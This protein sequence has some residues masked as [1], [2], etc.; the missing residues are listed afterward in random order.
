LALILAAL[1]NSHG[2]ETTKEYRARASASK[3]RYRSKK[4][5]MRK[6]AA[7]VVWFILLAVLGSA[8]QNPT[9]L[10]PS[11][12][13][14]S[15]ALIPAQ[16]PA[17]D[18]FNGSGVVDP[19]VP[20][21][22]KLSLLEALDRGLK[23]NLGLLLSQQQTEQAR[24]QYR[25]QLSTL[26]PNISATTSESINQINLA[27]FGI[28]LPAGLTSP[29]I[30]P[31][32]VFDVHA[33][34]SETVLDFNARNKIRAAQENQKTAQFTVQD[35]RELVVLVVG[36]QYLLTLANAARLET[37]KA[38]FTTAQTIFQ[39]TQDLKKAGVAAGIDVLRAQVE[40]QSQQQRVLA[41]QNQYDQ[42]KMT[43]ARTIG[44]SVAQA[45][46][47]TDAVPYAA[48]PPLDL[49]EA[50]ARAYQ[51]RP[52]YLAAQSRTRASELAVKAAKG[53]G[54]PTVDVNGQM[55]LLG[56]SPGSSEGTYVLSAG[57]HIP[58]FQG[59]KVKADV[60]QA[61]VLW[62]QNKLQLE[63]LHSR[64]EFEVRS[65]LLDVKT[66]EDQIAVAQQQIALAAEQL[67]E[68]QDRYAAG[69][70]G[71]LEVVQSQEAVVSANDNHI[72]AL[73][74]NNVAKLSLV[75]ALGDAETR[76]RAFLGG[77]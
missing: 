63:N 38:Q 12:E 56:A 41:A 46:E 32:G 35:A 55:G 52:E 2:L 36:N 18:T 6:A 53:E 66:S 60:A 5:R 26:L 43:L 30:G 13:R 54:L 25:R 7:R 44:L 69:V 27:A 31:F 40:M 58:I 37:A 64:I 21:V 24:A 77:K 57:V 61:E 48:L 47:L 14:Q 11:S 50:L 74:R 17:L 1:T 3:K 67:K 10:A 51:R 28:P 20:G 73:Y 72:E 70:S 33:S 39:Q 68:A 16:T 34:M 23:R 15:P 45:F 42:Q 22:V 75:R 29:V 76:T 49:P 65:A 8:A 4:V 71:S 62:R 59:G 9:A 19:L